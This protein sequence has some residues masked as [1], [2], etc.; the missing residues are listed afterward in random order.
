MQELIEILCTEC[1]DGV[2]WL[3]FAALYWLWSKISGHIRKKREF[4]AYE[5]RRLAYS[6]KRMNEIRSI[7]R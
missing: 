5:R 6:Q 7:Y 1:G 3:T 2:L 4:A